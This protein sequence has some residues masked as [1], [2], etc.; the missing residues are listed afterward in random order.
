VKILTLLFFMSSSV[1]AEVLNHNLDVRLNIKK[2]EIQVSDVIHFESPKKTF[3]FKLHKNLNI[4]QSEKFSIKKIEAS[5][6]ELYNS[7]ILSFKKREKST[8]VD[9]KGVIN[10]TPRNEN[11]D[12]TI[13]SK[14]VVLFGGTGWYPRTENL[15]KF[16]LKVS[17]L[18]TWSSVSNGFQENGVWAE[19][20]PQDDI[21]LIAGDFKVFEKQVGSILVSAYLFQEDK[22]LADKFLSITGQ[23]LSMYSSQI[24]GYPYKKFSVV[25]NFFQTGYGMPSFTLLGS[26]VIR[27]PFIFY[28]SYPHEILHNWWGNSVYIDFKNGNWAEG[29][30]TYQSDHALADMRGGGAS[31]RQTAL[32]TYKDYVKKGKDFPLI[33]F[34]GRHNAVTQAIGYNKT[35]MFFHMLKIK[36]GEEVF[37]K[38]L[39][40]FYKSYKFKLAS[41]PEL[42]K[43]FNTVSGQDLTKFFDQW[44]KKVGSA[45]LE[46][47]NA[48]QEE[49]EILLD[50]EQVQKG[51][52][53][54]LKIPVIVK[55][56][57]GTEKSFIEMSKKKQS[58]K[59]TTKEPALEVKLDPQ[60]DIFRSLDDSEVA[61]ALSG[62]YGTEKELYFIY[63]ANSTL[64]DQFKEMAQVLAQRTHPG[65]KIVSDNEISELPKKSS[66]WI[67]GEENKFSKKVKDLLLPYGGAIT[68][69]KLELPTGT[70][71][72][73]KEASVLVFKEK[74]LYRG[75]ITSRDEVLM[76]RIPFK[77]THYGKYSFLGFEGEKNVLKGKWEA[78]GSPL[79]IKF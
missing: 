9:Y 32:Q 78:L 72:L 12:G 57:N 77:I 63:P 26:K 43:S 2:S 48:K 46:I 1:Y 24:G 49:G 61:P 10:H 16:T 51:I 5:K 60:Y 8:V 20:N 7:F 50:L 58:F 41:Y 65:A 59:I 33:E 35:M 27:L 4:S 44:T 76:K 68:S 69:Q 62:I 66:Y 17:G 22:E 73:R 47:K 39:S 18:G 28:T 11:S 29:L 34:K 79:N 54:D 56:K 23:Y 6:N 45:E 3:S 74:A 31:Y 38:S 42:L 70:I 52:S 15:V 30:T 71:D 75:F 21:Y 67:L 53:Y 14:G 13:S 40:H 25:E 19:N 36:L 64:S 37:N 55:T